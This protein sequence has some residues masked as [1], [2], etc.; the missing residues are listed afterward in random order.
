MANSDTGS[1]ATGIVAIFAILLM[2][3]VAG[4]IAWRAGVF[5]GAGDN[6]SLDININTPGSR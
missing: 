2:I 1:G 4:F 6:K 5:G 3:M